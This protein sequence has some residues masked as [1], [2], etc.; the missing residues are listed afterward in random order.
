[1]A[2][3]T[4]TT[5]TSFSGLL[6]ASSADAGQGKSGSSGVGGLLRPAEAAEMQRDALSLLEVFQASIQS[7]K[8]ETHN[9]SANNAASSSSSSSSS[10]STTSQTSNGKGSGKP[11]TSSRAWKQGD[12]C[13]A[14]WSEDGIVY[15]A[16]IDELCADGI[17]C[18]V[19]YTEYGNQE[20]QS[21]EDLL[22]PTVAQLE[23]YA[24]Q[25]LQEAQL[26]SS[27]QLF[28]RESS[29]SVSDVSSEASDSR[30]STTERSHAV[31]RTHKLPNAP[32]K[33]ESEELGAGEKSKPPASSATANATSTP[34]VDSSQKIEADTSSSATLPRQPIL[35]ENAKK[36]PKQPTASASL[37]PR[38]VE[39]HVG[40]E[41]ISVYSVDQREYPA[42][43]EQI[44]D[45]GI[46]CIVKYLGYNN[47][48]EVELESLQPN[49]D[50]EEASATLTATATPNVDHSQF[51]QPPAL[52]GEVLPHRT[53]RS[54]LNYFQPGTMLAI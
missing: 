21:L 45:D 31:R 50:S 2:T 43:I 54:L 42:V 28:A 47:K 27:T 13:R 53:T 18:W 15:N 41:C 14:T 10:S 19:T 7:H 33:S 5:T 30:K 51:V 22:P 4:T 35:L 26:R 29:G 46:Y 49:L 3:A 32:P 37:E 1:M 6:N 11:E 39:W 38:M 48:E 36:K 44:S 40:D 24:S 12:L 25:P 23:E 8:D 20:R 9:A 52:R 16:T 17:H 34:K